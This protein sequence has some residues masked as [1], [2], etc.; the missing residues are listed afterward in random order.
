MAMGSSR[1]FTSQSLSVLVISGA[2]LVTSACSSVRGPRVPKAFMIKDRDANIVK[3]IT[4]FYNG[5]CLNDA[6]KDCT[7]DERERDIIVYDLKIVIDR[8]YE[9]Y[10]RAFEQTQ[11]TSVFL[12]EVSGASLTG[13]ATLVEDMALKDI[14]TT[15]SSLVQSTSVSVQKNYYQKQTS[16]AILNVMDADRAK[17]WSQI[18]DLLVNNGLADYSLSAAL[19]DLVEYRRAGTAIH[20]L[21]SIQQ[22][23]GAQKTEATATVD[24][25]NKAAG[26]TTQ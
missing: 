22:A 9:D 10:A 1:V 7:P 17:K 26:K 19:A 21:T 5:K 20:A 24:K 4:N 15:A 3:E 16:Y 11:D 12:G 8:N 2:M 14:L 18:Y 13:V 6:S 25:T 23:A